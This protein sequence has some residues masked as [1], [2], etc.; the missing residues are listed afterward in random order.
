MNAII[1]IFL[2]AS[3]SPPRKIWMKIFWWK[4]SNTL[5]GVKILSSILAKT[6]IQL[7]KTNSKHQKETFPIFK[8][9]DQRVTLNL[10]I[11]YFLLL[12]FLYLSKVILIL[13]V[14]LLLLTY[15]FRNDIFAKLL[16]LHSRIRQTLD[17]LNVFNFIINNDYR[18]SS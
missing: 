5:E 1:E 13:K 18:V 15:D 8:T 6:I 10:L 4:I 7:I 14:I 12:K 16:L 11:L 9:A 3:L 17:V 2:A